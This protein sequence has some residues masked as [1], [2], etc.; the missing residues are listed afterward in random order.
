MSDAPI[1]NIRVLVDTKKQ[2][3]SFEYWK[4]LVP[5][6]FLPQLD[7]C[8]AT[9]LEFQE[10]GKLIIF[11]KDCCPSFRA[12]SRHW[13]EAMDFA[14]SLGWVG[15]DDVLNFVQLSEFSLMHSSPV[16]E[17]GDSD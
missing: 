7:S 10:S 3:G 4:K 16:S 8:I 5:E 17:A 11:T 14:E 1:Y 2:D 6:D 12:V 13:L 9:L 15:S